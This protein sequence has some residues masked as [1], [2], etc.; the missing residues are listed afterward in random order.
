[1][2]GA[3]W[4]LA[5]FGIAAAL[6][7]FAGNNQGTITLYWP[8]YRVDL[9]LNL[10][11]L[12]LIGAFMVLHMALRALAALFA[13]PD[14]ARRWRLQH[15]ERLLHVALLDA[16]SH[17]VAGRFIRARKSAQLVALQEGYLERGGERLYYAPRL[18]A[19]AHL[20]GAESAHALQDRAARDEHLRQALASS[21][22]K[23]ESQETREG[24]QLRAAQW[25]VADRDGAA[26]LKW[27]DELPH[28]AARRTLALRLRLKAARMARQTLQALETARLLAKHRAFSESAARG[29]LR[30]LAVELIASMHDPAQLQ[31]TW[32]QLEPV[33]REVPEVALAA[34]ARLLALDGEVELSRRWLLPVWER[35]VG[36]GAPLT[37]VQRVG[38]VR[39]LESGFGRAAGAPDGAWLTRIESAQLAS[40]GDA[41]LQYLAGVT[42]MHLQLWGKAQQ[43]L[44]QSL[45]RLHDPELQRNAWRL[46]AELAQRRDEPQ[47]AAEAWRAAASVTAP[48]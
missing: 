25:A 36:A 21:T 12:L 43:L 5:L 28:G 31:R 7:L 20:L 47:A 29:V 46:V 37:E 24:V 6:A 19:I 41:L 27:L 30:S 15:K 2:R 3:L 14:Q 48:G 10:V 4:L 13:M 44:R 9:S 42:C 40:P 32:T 38:L 45:P 26:A 39:G 11:L 33:E 8:P 34:A 35:M 22:A 16:V 18:R 17:L 1:M 23:G